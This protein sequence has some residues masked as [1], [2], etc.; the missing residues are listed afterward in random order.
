MDV[1]RAL[2]VSFC[3]LFLPVSALAAAQQLLICYGDSITAGYGLPYGQSYPDDLQRLLN[4][5]GYHYTVRNMGSSGATTADAVANLPS[6]LRQ[7]P[8]VVVVEFGGNDGLRG[9]PLEQTRRNL[10]QVLTT[11]QS[12]HIKILLAGIT[13]PPNYGQAYIHSFDQL[14]RTLAAK[15]RV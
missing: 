5:G 2:L 15:H 4:A 13:L 1:R 12:A 14:F 11:L 8:A 10:G 9:L 3:L 7:H 6:V